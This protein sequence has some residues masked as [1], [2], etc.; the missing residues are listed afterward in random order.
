MRATWDGIQEGSFDFHVPTFAIWDYMN[1]P[2]IELC[3]WLI[4]AIAPESI[5]QL[6]FSEYVHL[7]SFFAVFGLE[8]KVRFIFGYV[9]TKS[10]QTLE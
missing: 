4:E 8:E 6:T 3:N 2:R 1:I 5:L 7:I 9:C 10:H